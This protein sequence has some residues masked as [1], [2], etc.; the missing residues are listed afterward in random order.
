MRKICL[1]ESAA[2]GWMSVFVLTIALVTQT[3]SAETTEQQDP[4]QLAEQWKS[5]SLSELA[6][7]GERVAAWEPGKAKNQASN[8]MRIEMAGRL[9]QPA[10]MAQADYSI[11]IYFC[12]FARPK[13]SDEDRTVLKTRF[14]SRADNEAAL[15]AE[16]L[17]AKY[18]LMHDLKATGAE[19]WENHSATELLDLLDR[20]KAFPPSSERGKTINAI[21]IESAR[22]LVETTALESEDYEKRTERH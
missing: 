16:Q 3:N 15:S 18:R 14:V 10:T 19:V 1:A 8:L 4:Q 13:I 11:L 2:V 20:A 7:E 6:Q 5:L 22:R 12:K 9:M 17:F 21:R